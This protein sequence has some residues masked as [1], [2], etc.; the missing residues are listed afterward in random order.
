MSLSVDGFLRE[1]DGQRRILDVP[2]GRDHSGGFES[3]RRTVWG[4]EPV[5]ALGARFLPVPAD[6]DLDIETEEVAE[7]LR[8]VAL[9]PGGGR[10]AR[11]GDPGRRA[12]L[13][14]RHTAAPARAVAGPGR[15]RVTGRGAAGTL[16]LLPECAGRA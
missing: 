2:E 15:R 4:S 13:V 10:P 5:R 3:W 14:R 6:D 1:P 12:D 8:E 11:P 7:F 16:A 9:E